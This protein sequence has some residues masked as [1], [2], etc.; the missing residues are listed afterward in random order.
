[1]SR[2]RYE[3]TITVTTGAGFTLTTTEVVD[4]NSP[5]QAKELAVAARESRYHDGATTDDVTDASPFVTL[6]FSDGTQLPTRPSVI[7]NV[8][9]ITAYG[10]LVVRDSDLGS[11]Y[12]LTTCCQASAKGSTDAIVCRSC[13]TEVS[14][15]LGGPIEPDHTVVR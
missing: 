11:P 1:M 15:E 6:T 3:C 7:E 2:S 13:Y 5:E 14:S 9:G 12:A 4:A 10:E 8:I